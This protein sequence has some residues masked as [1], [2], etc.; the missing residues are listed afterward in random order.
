MQRSTT[1]R[2]GP[3]AALRAG[4]PW[5]ALALALL[6]GTALPGHAKKVLPEGGGADP[7][8][9]ERLD[10][11]QSELPNSPPS[12]GGGST[13]T[14]RGSVF[15]N[16]QR[17]EDG[18]WA[19]RFYPD[20]TQGKQCDASVNVPDCSA[21]TAR[22]A[23]LRA[24]R[25]DQAGV[26][27]MLQSPAKE[28]AQ[29]WL[30]ELDRQVA[31][32]EAALATCKKRCGLNWLGGRYMVVDVIERDDGFAI[33]D[34]NCKREDVIASATVGRNGAFVAT[35]PVADAC[36]HDDLST[37]VELRVRLRFCSDRYC[38]SINKDKNEPYAL[39]HPGASAT[40][41]L[42]VKVGDDVTVTRIN[43]N[44]G[45]DPLAPNND[46]IAANY[47]ASIVDTILK[48]HRDNPIPFYESEFGELQY[49]FPS[50][51]SG[52]ATA[53]SPTEVAISTFQSQPPEL[54]GAYAWIS[55]K[56]P[57]HEYGHVMMQRAW[58]GAYGFDGVGEGDPDPDNA[59]AP[60]V[61]IAFKEAWADFIARVVF[62]PTRGCERPDFDPNDGK[63]EDANLEGPLGQGAQWRDNIVKALCDWY[64]KTIDDDRKL[65]GPGDRFEA[66]DIHSMWSNLR[67]M[68]TEADR[69]G[70]EFRKPGLWF[71]DYVRYYLDVRKSAAA[72][73]A[74]EHAS[75]EGKVR[76][77]LYNNNIGCSMAPPP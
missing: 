16:D 77:L 49:I 26:V 55:G 41:P 6:F 75:Y 14:I 61:Q 64:D 47:Y 17:T 18:L 33:T 76:D 31:A 40:K 57:A 22:L 36:R 39:S 5:L 8:V 60:S 37:A 54:N 13:A 1:G 67:G 66:E 23:D 11:A 50:T 3:R 21:I 20:G 51:K 30:D 69:Y 24:Q 73:G 59:A 45:S 34:T 63:A 62:A 9:E 74:A 43:F 28:R 72:V 12:S 2:R 65:A 71:C 29:L 7:E 32:E 70:G 48:L 42:K 44:T 38:F 68:Y 19:E 58:G 35:F 15:Y 52:T 46:S 10:D 25:D 27:A 4:A 53:R 56:T